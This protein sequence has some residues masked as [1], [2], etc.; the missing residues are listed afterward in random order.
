MREGGEAG[1]ASRANSLS[2]LSDLYA[3]LQS[4]GYGTDADFLIF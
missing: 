1:A 4:A 3:D 2:G